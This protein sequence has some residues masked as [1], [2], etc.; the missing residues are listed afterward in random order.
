MRLASAAKGAAEFDTNLAAEPAISGEIDF[1]HAAGVE[2]RED[3][4]GPSRL[5]LITS[6]MRSLFQKFHRNPLA[7]HSSEGEY[8]AVYAEP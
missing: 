2:R 5:P 1:A 4:V 8:A 7:T 6:V 3:F